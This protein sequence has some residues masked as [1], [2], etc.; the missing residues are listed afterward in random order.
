MIKIREV[1]MIDVQDWDDLVSK[2]YGRPYS[3]QQ[4]DGC[5]SRGIVTIDIPD[6]DGEEDEMHDEI[7]FVINGSTMGVKF[8][9]WKNA[10]VEDINSNF[11]DYLC[12]IF[13]DRNFYP[14]LQSVA[15]DLLTRGLIEADRYCI[16]I[17][18]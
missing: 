10:C 17:D 13:W 2:T 9:V 4:Q 15:N 6:D 11:K 3:L 14:S 18:W 7:P 12:G 16:N 8:D 5:M 1:K